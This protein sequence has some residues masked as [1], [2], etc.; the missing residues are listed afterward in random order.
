MVLHQSLPNYRGQGCRHFLCRHIHFG[1]FTWL[2]QGPVSS[3]LFLIHRIAKFWTIFLTFYIE[4][5]RND[6]N[7]NRAAR[8]K[9]FQSACFISKIYLYTL[10]GRN[11]FHHYVRKL[12][13]IVKL[14]HQLLSSYENG[15]VTD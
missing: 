10:I 11:S 15:H 4:K 3:Y 9:V 12:R 14:V 7:M 2:F 6:W 8:H 1:N 5:Y 13:K